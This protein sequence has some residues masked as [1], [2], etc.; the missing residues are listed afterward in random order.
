MFPS[1][2]G[3]EFYISHINDASVSALYAVLKA[4][5]FV[6]TALWNMTIVKSTIISERELDL[7]LYFCHKIDLEAGGLLFEIYPL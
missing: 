2:T 5:P 4:K 1:T 3:P 7:E 6:S